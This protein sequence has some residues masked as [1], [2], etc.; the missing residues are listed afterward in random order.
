[1]ATTAISAPAVPAALAPVVDAFPQ[2][3]SYAF[4]SE[5]AWRSWRFR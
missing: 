3:S 2:G 5:Q 4:A 1:M